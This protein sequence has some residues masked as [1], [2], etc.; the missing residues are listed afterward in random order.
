MYIS[1]P[2]EVTNQTTTA[3]IQLSDLYTTHYEGPAKPL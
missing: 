2:P 3:L 1:L